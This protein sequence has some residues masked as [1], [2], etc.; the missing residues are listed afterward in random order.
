M[1]LHILIRS[2]A[3]IPQATLAWVLRRP[4]PNVRPV[5]LDLDLDVPTDTGLTL[6]DALPVRSAEYWLLL[7]E[8]H[9]AERELAGLSAV[10]QSHPWPA[11]VAQTTRGRLHQSPSSVSSV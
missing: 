10:A 3:G 8:P 9:L 1:N 5:Q 2:L 4:L 11:R 7:G 6:R